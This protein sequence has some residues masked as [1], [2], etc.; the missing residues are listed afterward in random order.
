MEIIAKKEKLNRGIYS[1]GIGFIDHDKEEL[2]LSVV[3]RTLLVQKI[4]LNFRLEA[5]LL[6]TQM[7]KVNCL[8]L[9]AK[10]NY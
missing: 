3:I 10:P 1:G 8:K 9:L 6:T 2:N 4:I 5:A 7:L